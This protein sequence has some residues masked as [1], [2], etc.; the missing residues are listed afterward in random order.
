MRFRKECIIVA[1]TIL[2]SLTAGVQPGACQTAIPCDSII[3]LPYTDEQFGLPVFFTSAITSTTIGSTT[4]APYCDVRGTIWPD[5]GFNIKVPIG[6][7]NRRFYMTGTR[8]ENEAINETGMLRALQRGFTTAASKTGYSSVEPYQWAYNPIDNSN[9]YA[10]QKQYDFYYRANHETAVLA[11]KIMGAYYG[12]S[13]P[14]AYSYFEGLSDAGRQA[15]ILAQFYPL[16]FDGIIAASPM[17]NCAWGNTR[18]IWNK[19]ARLEADINPDKLSIIANAVYAKCDS[20]D[21]LV[22]GFIDDPRKCPF[23][24]DADLPRCQGIEGPNCFTGAQIDTI[25]KIY[26]GPSA[27]GGVQIFPGASFGSEIADTTGLSGWQQFGAVFPMPG[28]GETLINDAIGFLKYMA[29]EPPVNPASY[30]YTTFNID[31]DLKNMANTAAWCSAEQPDL[32]PY[33]LTGGKLIQWHGLADAVIPPVSSI[34]YYED[35]LAVMGEDTAKSFFR[36]FM[37][38]GVFNGSGGI[39]CGDI[40][41]LAVMQDWRES[42]VEPAAV[43]GTRSLGGGYSARTRPICSYPEFSRYLGTGSIDADVN[44][45]C[46]RIVPSSVKIKPNRININGRGTFRVA[47]TLPA[48][49]DARNFNQVA[50]TCE[51]APGEKIKI[52]KKGSVLKAKFTKASLKNITSGRDVIFSVTAIFEQGGERIAFEGSELIRVVD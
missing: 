52:S 5:I 49:Y 27:S 45:T 6:E 14:L 34:N 1:V 3:L 29:F 28:Q 50:V 13:Q 36:F 10:K 17:M 2:I 18:Y 30:N 39:G 8:F 15:L 46:T 19:L 16:D 26:L 20:V 23:D 51:G 21:G 24:P 33:M 43:V 40:D 42:G 32:L 12:I 4:V 35:V 48:G 9:P 25:K 47:M 41:W 31:T 11:K 44:F 22:D 7:W 37:V 38:P